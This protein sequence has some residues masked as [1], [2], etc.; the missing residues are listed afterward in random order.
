MQKISCSDLVKNR[1]LHTV[2]EER[3]ILLILRRK[4]LIGHML[5]RNCLLKH[6][7]EGKM[8]GKTRRGTRHQQLLDDL[9]EK[10][11][12]WNLKEEALPG[13]AGITGFGKCCGPVVRN[14]RMNE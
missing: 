11:R 14:Y 12:C 7:I 5:R 1:V 6:V 3:N 10:M 8:G 9:K 2:K 13:T 4:N